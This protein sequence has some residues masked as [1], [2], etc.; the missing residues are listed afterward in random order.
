ME[1]SSDPKQQTHYSQWLERYTDP[2]T[3]ALMFSSQN[4]QYK[5]QRAKDR[6]VKQSHLTWY[7][8]HRVVIYVDNMSKLVFTA[9]GFLFLCMKLDSGHVKDRLLWLEFDLVK[10]LYFWQ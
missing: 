3:Q 5:C 8:G 6:F 10:Q 9:K 1:G 4:L 2:D 7:E